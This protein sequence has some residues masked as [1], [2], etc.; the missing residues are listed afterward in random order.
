MKKN[1]VI[2]DI[3]N[4]LSKLGDLKEKVKKQLKTQYDKGWD[5]AKKAGKKK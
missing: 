2:E 1:K 5:K 4:I 3:E